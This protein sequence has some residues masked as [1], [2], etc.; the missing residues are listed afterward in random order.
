M[1]KAGVSIVDIS[2]EKGI[3]LSGYPHCPRNNLGIHDPL[4]ASCIYLNNGTED[5]VI[6]AMDLLFFGR[7][8]VLEMRERIGK[9]VFFT[10]TH[11]HSG[12]RVSQRLGT[13][14]DTPQEILDQEKVYSEILLNKLEPAIREAMDN[15]FEAE[16]GFEVG[17]CG[18]EQGVGGNRRSKDGLC[19]PSVNVMA[20]R[21]KATK[22]VRGVFLNYALH[23]TFMHED[24][25]LVSADY[26]A[27]TRRYLSF[28][29]PDAVFLFA[30]GTSG[31][32]SSR[33]FRVGQDFDEAARVGTT[34]GVE[35]FHCLERMEYMSE[36]KLGIRS[37]FV[38][39]DIKTFPPREEAEAFLAEKRAH[40]ESLKA[41]GA[42]WL[43]CW[44]AELEMFGAEGVVGYSIMQE[45]GFENPD[46]PAEIQILTFNDH[47]IVGLQGE[48][49]VEYGLQIKE[50]SPFK[51]TFVT[52]V[53]NGVLPGYCYTPEAVA[54]GGYEVGN[55]SL[56]PN[57]GSQFVQ[58]AVKLLNE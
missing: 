53:T 39:P 51:T 18:G 45:T 31:N 22:K 34:L 4:Y 29:A 55:S 25:L 19:D 24:N 50:A 20:V 16:L 8:Y 37:T 58:A 41:S 36:V 46:L 48:Q 26:P 23:P 56:A 13:E 52:A 43:D 57:A 47:A 17:K 1:L 33:Y 2:P 12:P 32:Q 6:V 54:D 5:V 14:L 40:W 9:P 10:C 3:E 42:S 15:T 30:Q 27:Y 11:T 44:N 38:N 21:E 7:P 28:A 35:V 49:F